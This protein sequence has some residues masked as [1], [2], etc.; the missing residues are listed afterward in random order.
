M[1]WII[2]LIIY[3]ILKSVNMM[4]RHNMRALYEF[5]LIHDLHYAERPTNPKWTLISRYFCLKVRWWSGYFNNWQNF[6][7]NSLHSSTTTEK[8]NYITSV[9]ISAL[10]LNP[11][12]CIVNTEHKNVRCFRCSFVFFFCV[13]LCSSSWTFQLHFFALFFLF[14]SSYLI[15]MVKVSS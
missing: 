4:M 5:I 15:K 11:F 7:K 9:V 13:M 1:N 12:K 6:I 8:H 14:Y 3:W 10:Q 2:S